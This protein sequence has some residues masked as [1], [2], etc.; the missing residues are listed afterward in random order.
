[1]SACTTIDLFAHIVV[2]RD[3]DAIDLF[4]PSFQF[5]VAPQSSDEAPCVIKGTIPPDGSVPI[6][7]H[8]GVEACFV[9]SGT[10]EVLRDEGGE[11]HWIAASPGDFI[12]VPS[13]AKHGFRNRSQHPVVQLITIS[14]KLGRLFQEIGRPITRGARPNPP[15]PDELQ[16]LVKTCERYGYWLGTPEENA[17]VGVAPF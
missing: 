2:E 6:H 7:R 15:S 5:L 16:R 14:S 10:V 1:M 8:S 4:G 3:C 12:E 17:S 13:N 9:L 11:A